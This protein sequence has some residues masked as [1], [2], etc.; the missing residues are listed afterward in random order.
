MLTDEAGAFAEYWFYA[1]DN[2]KKEMLSVALTAITTGKKVYVQAD[3]PKPSNSPYT[4][5][6]NLY[7]VAS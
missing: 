1:A 2:S 6:S 3:E 5:I 7:L 4:L